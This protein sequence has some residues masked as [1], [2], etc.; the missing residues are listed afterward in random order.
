[1]I[2]GAHGIGG[3][4]FSSY[5]LAQELGAF[6]LTFILFSGGMGTELRVIRPVIKSALSLSTLGVLIATVLV[7]VFAYLALGFSLLEGLLLGVTIAST[8]VAAVFSVLRSKNVRLKDGLAPLLELESALNDPMAV[9]LG[10]ALLGLA[11]KSGLSIW[12]LFPLFLRQVALGSLLG[13]GLGKFAVL[14][15]NRIKLEY[16]GLYPVLTMGWIILTYAL[17]QA[18]GGSGFLAVYISGILIGNANLVHRKS[19]IHFHEGIAWLGQIGMFLVMGLLVSPAALLQVAPFGIALSVFLML[20][21]RPVSVFLSLPQSRFNTR[22]KLMVSWAGLRGAVP[23]ILASY[24]LAAQIPRAM[25]IFNLVFFV[26][27]FSVLV[28]GTTIPIVSKWLNVNLPFLEKFRFP[29]EFNPG[30]NIKNNLVE[31]SV[32]QGSRLVGKSLLEL[33]LPSELLIV[34]IQRSGDILIPRGG[35]HIEALDTLLVLSE[36]ESFDEV[37]NVLL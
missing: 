5:V 11:N 33:E 9:F 36:N 24:V 28:Q 37:R 4:P 31:I 22:E 18:L 25:E 13:F 14:L 1:M 21:A 2:A 27:F 34:L 20:L 6:A 19:L 3:V 8:D 12:S 26:T 15:I 23:I 30:K 17:T 16:E 7:G 29:I 32:P 35:T 10:V